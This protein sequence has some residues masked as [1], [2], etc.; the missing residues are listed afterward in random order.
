MQ[1]LHEQEAVESSL[2]PR[3]LEEVERALADVPPAE[4]ARLLDRAR[5]EIELELELRQLGPDQA[6]TVLTAK[7]TPEALAQ[8][9][10]SDAPI[11]MVGGLEESGRLA[12]CR[13]CRREVAR[14]AMQ[15]PHC[16][17]PH[18]SR[19]NWRGWGYEWRSSRTL[20]G[21]PLVHVAF[22]RD[23]RGKLRVANGIIA[24]G[25]FAKGVIAIGQ[26]AAGG[27]LAVGQFALAPLALGQFALGLF[28][29]GQFG[30]GVLF[31]AGMI[32]TGL[33][34]KGMVAIGNFFGR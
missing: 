31:G 7:G 6:L 11:P 18:P 12:S 30:L 25:Q 4:R 26:F 5:A 14:Q 3:Y 17:A 15:C 34:A 23:E 2:V 21:R 27:V 32:A 24:I 33:V 10:R 28:A 1:Q 20:W 22:G 9:L 8:R 16:G 13:C 29:A 19:Q